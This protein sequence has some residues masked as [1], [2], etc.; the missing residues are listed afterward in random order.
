MSKSA[1]ID[2]PVYWI[3]EAPVYPGH[4]ITCALIV[5][6]AYGDDLATAWATNQ[7][8]W[9]NCES[10]LDV[11]TAGGALSSGCDLI[12]YVLAGTLTIDGAIHWGDRAWDGAGGHKDREGPGR[13]Q[14]TRLIP[15]LRAALEAAVDKAAS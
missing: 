10:D 7:Y 14:A 4:P 1:P 3:G 15:R 12:R 8:G 9:R 2:G 11:P 5:L 13:E 6:L